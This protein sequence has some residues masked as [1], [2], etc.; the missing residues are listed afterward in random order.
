M[1][2]QQRLQRAKKI[3]KIW[4]I[5]G[6]PWQNFGHL[7]LGGVDTCLIHPHP[8]T[9]LEFL[10]HHPLSHKY[11]YQGGGYHKGKG[12]SRYSLPWPRALRP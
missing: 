10:L 11:S 4:K 8:P 9:H 3:F 6:N 12:F 5:R 1:V 2:S 7:V